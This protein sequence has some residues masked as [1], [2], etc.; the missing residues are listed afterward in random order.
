M[1]T[2]IFSSYNGGSDLSRM[3]DSL[4][5]MKPPPGGWELIA[6]DNASTDGTG[7]L[8]RSYA[9][10]LPITVLEEPVKGKNRALNRALSRAQG[11][12]C[13]FTDD[14][15]LV[16]EDWLGAWQAVADAQPGHD[17]FAGLTRALFP[18]TPPQWILSGIP[19]G[20]VFAAHGPREKEGPTDVVNMYGT[21]MAVRASVFRSGIRFD[22]GIGP[23]GSGNYPMGSDTEFGARLARLGAKCWF[24]ES[25]FVH[26]I[27][28]PEHLRAGWILRR[29]Y[30][31]GRGLARMGYA[32]HCAPEILARKNDLKNLVYP[33]L[34]PFLDRP[35]RW[36]RQWQFMVDRGYE[37]GTR[38]LD[39][40][41]P[42][43]C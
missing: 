16:C 32:F 2:V 11:D 20:V 36:R 8:M 3:L 19:V 1:I 12:L 38:D 25:A 9:G 31:W 28:P 23:D 10:R 6:V 42:R 26:H 41:K 21:N 7:A 5:Q 15:V 29:A 22:A 43:W 30:R 13:V 39:G 27:V 35:H 34:L 18:A 37:D 33:F 40:R 17:M 24:S 4:V 14:D